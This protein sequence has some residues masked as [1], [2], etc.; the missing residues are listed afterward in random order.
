MREAIVLIAYAA[1]L[2][3]LLSVLPLWVD[4]ILQLIGTT[5]PTLHGVFL[6]STYSVGATPLGT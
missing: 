3:P 2:A 1:A 4:E 6:W 5:S